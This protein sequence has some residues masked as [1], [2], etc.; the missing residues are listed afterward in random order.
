MAK[1]CIELLHCMEPRV[2]DL[3][4]LAVPQ[5]LED[6]VNTTFHPWVSKWD[7][8]KQFFICLGQVNFGP[9]SQ[10]LHGEFPAA[11]P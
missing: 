9:V 11:L 4:M 1:L 6:M 3:H 8:L 5:V 7:I 10:M 2:W